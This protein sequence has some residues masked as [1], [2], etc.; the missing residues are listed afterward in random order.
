MLDAA[1]A[2]VAS[3]RER[4][5]V[6]I[7][8]DENTKVVVQGLTGGRA[9]TTACATARTAPRSWPARPRARAG[10]DVEGIPIFDTVAEA[11]SARAPRVVHLRPRR[12][13][14][15][16]RS[17]RRPK[18]GIEFVMCITEGV[19]AQDEARCLQHARTRL[20]RHPA[21]RPQLPRH[22]QPRRVQHRHHRGRDREGA[23][24][25]PAWAS[26]AARARSPTRP[27]TS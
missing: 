3:W 20:P 6:A 16:A 4:P 1:R 23:A 2:A 8:V 22:H 15:R 14:S 21:A 5:E 18:A 17:S 10:T 27:S 19:P 7:F 26:S 12:P 24:A 11:V 9:S 25:A 13:A